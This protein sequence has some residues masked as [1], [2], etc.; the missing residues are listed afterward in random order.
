MQTSLYEIAAQPEQDINTPKNP[1][2][3]PAPLRLLPSEIIRKRARDRYVIMDHLK[4]DIELENDAPSESKKESGK[5][6]P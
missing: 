6:R 2:P 1:S 4:F 5:Q 3:S